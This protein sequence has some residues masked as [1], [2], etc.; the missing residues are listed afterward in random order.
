MFY[1][2]QLHLQSGKQSRFAFPQLQLDQSPLQE[3]LICSLHDEETSGIAIQTGTHD[4]DTLV[5]TKS[6]GD[7]FISSACELAVQILA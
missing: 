3:H 1:V 5:R 4:C 2:V 7:R 6:R